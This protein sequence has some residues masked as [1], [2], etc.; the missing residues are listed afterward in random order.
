MLGTG[1]KASKNAAGKAGFCDFAIMVKKGHEE[2]GDSAFAYEDGRKL[3]IAVLDGV[4]GEP[5]AAAASSEAAV[6]L[7]AFLKKCDKATGTVMKEAFAHAQE[8]VTAGFTTAAVI[9]LQKNGQFMIAT[10]GDSPVYGIEKPGEISLE[11]PI[12]RPVGENDSILKFFQLRAYVTSVLGP[13]GTEV[14]IN[15]AS[16]NF[17]KGQVLILATDGLTDNLYM[18]V[19]EGYVTD[20]S[21][22][23]DLLELIGKEQ[24]PQAMVKKLTA[25][26]ARRLK[27]GRK[28]RPGG[29]LVP[30]KDDIAIAVVRRL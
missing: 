18:A 9:F 11:L 3:I 13:S 5:G 1:V 25:E 28:E 4:S 2:C 23:K 6:A 26:I 15:M 12:S 17:T 21:G 7:L 27:A 29:V 24:K 14:H 20:P 22:K 10:V 16:G 8:N 30:K 19:S